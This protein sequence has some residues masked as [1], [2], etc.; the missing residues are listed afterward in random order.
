MV[1]DF[2][3]SWLLFAIVC[4]LPVKYIG[5]HGTLVDTTIKDELVKITDALLARLRL[6]SM[7][8]LAKDGFAESKEGSVGAIAAVSVVMFASL[9]II[10]V[11]GGKVPRKTRA[12]L[13]P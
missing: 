11:P 3:A 2:T 5:K 10:C 13:L 12:L 8:I 9:T 4:T 7:T 1:E 6:T